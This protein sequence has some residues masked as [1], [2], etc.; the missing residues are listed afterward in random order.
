MGCLLIPIFLAFAAAS[1]SHAQS[2]VPEPLRKVGI[3]QLLNQQVP[4]DIKFRD[5]AGREVA[6]GKYF[7]GK[8]VILSLVYY[9]C[10]MLCT[11]TL[12]GLVRTLRAMSLRV[13]EDFQIVT[14]SFD[15]NE[16]PDLAASSKSQILARYGRPRAEQGWHFLTGDQ[17]SID[18]L[19]QSVG[20]RYVPD[21]KNGQFAHA[22]G[23][24]VLTPKGKV[25]RYLFGVD[26]APRDLRLAL[27]EASAGKIGSRVDQMLLYCFHYD[28]TFGKYT[29]VVMNVI[30]A[31]GGAT[32]VLLGSFMIVMFRRDRRRNNVQ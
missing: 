28:P 5:E 3:D 30:R 24:M 23:I 29:M 1:S 31:L 4:P 2:E 8:P 11:M 14:V 19:V 27:V 16:K 22:S 12:E 10:P 9:H 32:V 18:A 17:P 26:Y 21:P 6:L 13:G 15:P 20:F 25:A 7:N